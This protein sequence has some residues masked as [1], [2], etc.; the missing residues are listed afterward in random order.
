MVV[1]LFS[2]RLEDRS[3]YTDL[4]AKQLLNDHVAGKTTVGVVST[5]KLP[6]IEVPCFE[7]NIL[8]WGIFWEQFGDMI[9][10]KEQLSDAYKL[11]YLQHALKDGTD[12]YAIQ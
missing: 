6:K 9:H 2:Q 8:N 7:G 11:A 10:I 12:K 5:V 4:H 3:D 1:G